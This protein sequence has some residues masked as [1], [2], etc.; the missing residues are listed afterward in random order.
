MTGNNSLVVHH[1]LHTLKEK[2]M[3]MKEWGR[4]GL[5][6]ISQI[7]EV[8]QSENNAHIE[9]SNKIINQNEE[10]GSNFSLIAFWMTFLASGG[11]C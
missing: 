3:V 7:S 6:L 2:G 4:E 10:M 9:S 1:A 5:G 11:Q 8:H